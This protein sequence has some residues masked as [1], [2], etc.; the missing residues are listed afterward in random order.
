MSQNRAH[1]FCSG[2]CTLPV[3]VLEQLSDQIVD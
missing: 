3:S 1:N 2:P